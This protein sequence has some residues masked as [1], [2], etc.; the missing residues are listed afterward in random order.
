M[1]AER[2]RIRAEGIAENA[3]GFSLFR[4][5][6]GILDEFFWRIWFVCIYERVLRINAFRVDSFRFCAYSFGLV[7]VNY[8]FVQGCF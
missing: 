8:K 5:D 4:A 1:R 6:G 3:G 2:D 7:N